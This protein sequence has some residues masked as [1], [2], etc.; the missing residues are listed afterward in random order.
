MGETAA[1][2]FL[3]GLGGYLAVGFVFAVAFVLMGAQRI[4]PTAAGM[5]IRARLTILPGSM[6]LWPLMAVKWMIQ[7]EPPV[8]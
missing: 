4:D 5:P 6:L 7:K 8:Q 2:L 1:T 3:T